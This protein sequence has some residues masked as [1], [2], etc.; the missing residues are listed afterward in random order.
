MK[1][2]YMY[3]TFLTT[4]QQKEDYIY[5]SKGHR[6][7]HERVIHSWIRKNSFRTRSWMLGKWRSKGN[8]SMIWN[9]V[10]V[11]Y[12][13]SYS[14]THQN[15]HR[16]RLSF[17]GWNIFM[18]RRNLLMIFCPLINTADCPQSFKKKRWLWQDNHD[19]CKFDPLWF[20]EYAIWSIKVLKEEFTF[21]S[22]IM[23]RKLG[24]G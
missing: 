24:M 16:I 8:Q 7:D 10:P 1:Y 6:L 20:V 9:H 5:F 19:D 18:C 14:L 15:W 23:F 12:K 4:C 3:I 17:V 11:V 21:L 2:T 22:I 13:N